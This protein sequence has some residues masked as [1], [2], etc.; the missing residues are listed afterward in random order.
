MRLNLATQSKPPAVLHGGQRVAVAQL[1]GVL[2]HF[3]KRNQGVAARIEKTV[4]Q[5]FQAWVAAVGRL[6]LVAAAQ[7]LG[8]AGTRKLLYFLCC[9]VAARQL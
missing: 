9:G 3:K 5:V 8:V 1:L 6:L 4:P 2:G 7:R